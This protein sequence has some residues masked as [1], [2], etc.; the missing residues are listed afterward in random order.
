[1]TPHRPHRLDVQLLAARRRPHMLITLQRLQPPLPTR[2][3][4]RA[5]PAPQGPEHA[6]ETEG[7]GGEV[8]VDEAEGC[9]EEEGALG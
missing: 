7:E 3:R 2:A 5:R 8:D 4:H 9:A 6:G 1:M